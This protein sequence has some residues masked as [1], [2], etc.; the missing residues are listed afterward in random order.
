MPWTEAV[1]ADGIE[2]KPHALLAGKTQKD[3]VVA[4]DLVLSARQSLKKWEQTVRSQR[5]ILN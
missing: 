5:Y 2:V 4:G 1:R 3:A